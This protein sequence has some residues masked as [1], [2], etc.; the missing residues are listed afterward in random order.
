MFLLFLPFF[1]WRRY[2]RLGW[3]RN[4]HI[5]IVFDDMVFIRKFSTAFT[6]VLSGIVV[7]H[8]FCWDFL[9]FS[10]FYLL[11]YPF[12]WPI[13][14][15]AC[16]TFNAIFKKETTMKGCIIHWLDYC[17]YRNYSFIKGLSSELWSQNTVIIYLYDAYAH[18]I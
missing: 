1:G 5:E 13:G 17:N 15:I 16:T 12:I 3:P 2:M 11:F 7:S 6:I 10:A 18:F 14:R 8:S 9:G 4:I